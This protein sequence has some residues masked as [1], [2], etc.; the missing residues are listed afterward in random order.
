M[1]VVR[2]HSV[3]PYITLTRRPGSRP[4]RAASVV[5]DIAAPVLVSSRRRGSSIG[6]RPSSRDRL[7]AS[8]GTTGRI[9]APVVAQCDTEAVASVR[10]GGEDQLRAGQSGQENLVE[11]V[12]EGERQGT[13]ND[14]AETVGQ[15]CGRWRGLR[16]S[17]VRGWETTA[18][19]ML[20]VPEV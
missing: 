6:R 4:R 12:V 20:V 11:A 13:K 19:G 14:V 1:I 3:R 5:A 18:F 7:S 9:V 2:L 17:S 15:L 16:R 8:E 10:R